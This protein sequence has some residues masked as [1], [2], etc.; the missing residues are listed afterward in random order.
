MIWNCQ[1]VEL[2]P[3]QQFF[4]QGSQ[5]YRL[6]FLINFINLARL[7]YMRNIR[8]GFNGEREGGFSPQNLHTTMI[9]D[10]IQW[11]FF[12]SRRHPFSKYLDPPLLRRNIITFALKWE[13][14]KILMAEK[15][16]HTNC[17]F[18]RH[19]GIFSFL[20]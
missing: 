3:A 5:H 18:F 16:F 15:W 17:G 1:I 10:Q 6:T 20:M 19:F 12:L 9:W 4:F 14:S 13:K 2:S 8:D 11:V 7:I